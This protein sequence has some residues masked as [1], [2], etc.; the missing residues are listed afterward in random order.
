MRKYIPLVTIAFFA[1]SDDVAPQLD[2]GGG[3]QDGG[4]QDGAQGDFAGD[5]GVPLTLPKGGTGHTKVGDTLKTGEVRAGRVTASTQLLSGVKVEGKVGDYKIYNDKVAFIIQD[6]RVSDGWNPYGGEVIDAA[7]IGKSSLLGEML[8]AV[9]VSIMKPTSV[10]VINDGSDGKAAI[11][12]AM[13]S[14]DIVPYLASVMGE[15]FGGKPAIHMV[16]DYILEPGSNA[17]QIKHRLLNATNMAQ[18]LPLMILALTGGDGA[19][20]YAQGQGFSPK[21]MTKLDFVGMIGPTVGYALV[22]LEEQLLPLV[23]YSGVWVHSSEFNKQVPAAGEVSRSFHLVVADGEP[24][25]VTREVRV[26]TK[27]TGLTKVSGTVKDAVGTAV[28]GA[29][30]HVQRDDTA[31]TYITMTRS[32]STGAYSVELAAGKYLFTVVAEDRA[33]AAA[34]KVTV[35]S[36]ASTQDMTVGT[37]GTIQVTVTDDTGV[38]IPT[39][40]VFTPKTAPGTYPAAFGEKKY[41]HGAKFIDFPADGKTTAKLPPDTYTVHASRGYEYEIATESI[42]LA[43]G[44][45]KTTTLKLKRSVDTTGYMCGDFHLH[46]MWSPD[47]SD[48]YDFKVRVLAAA[49][50]EIPVTTDHEYIADYAPYIAKLGLQKWIYGIVGEELTTLIYG[51]FNVYPIKQDPTKSNMGAHVWYK[52]PAPKM[53]TEVKKTW[54]NAIMQVNHP[55]SAAMGGYFT[56]VGWDPKAGTFKANKKDEWSSNFDAY[57]I[58]NSGAYSATRK[59]ILDW[60]SFLDR[61]FLVTGMGNSDSHNALNSEVGWPRNYV[62]LSTDTPANVSL[63]EFTKAVKTQQVS[64]SGGI[65]ATASVGGKG[66]GEVADAT[67]KKVEVA[68]KVQAPAWISATKLIVIMGGVEVKTITLDSSTADPTNA[69]IRYNGKIEL[70]PTKDTYVHVA[71]TG[72]GSL[73]P[74]SRGTPFAMTNPIYLDVDG[75]GAYDAAKTF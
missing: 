23:A 63:S 49:G 15:T 21:D 18:T 35:G 70:L 59:E 36:S 46:S 50:L 19:E 67:S 61:G 65:F 72:S 17:L 30:V 20:W 41:P 4:V 64:I 22:S 11:I 47:S 5:S 31:K 16:I 56:Y 52:Q 6:A 74:V 48:L 3:V 39:K 37:T 43:A 44:D 55:R 58:F 57:E 69:A 25:A 60:Y 73:A 68:V 28:A 29:R 26:L 45:T 40:V 1:C 62:K 7:Q 10:G 32:G 54:P 71:V 34:T 2:H 8:M 38:A 24:E 33:D 14:P 9:Y 27:K 42:T 53:F 12:R 51:H 13:G 75:N 66:M